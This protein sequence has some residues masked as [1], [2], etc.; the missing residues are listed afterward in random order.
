MDIL[1]RLTTILDRDP[2]ALSLLGNMN[3]AA[4]SCGFNAKQLL[5]A[6]ETTL[7]AAIKQNPEAFGLYADYI[8]KINN[9]EA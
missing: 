4:I 6:Q 5:K 3:E 7:L 2:K 9:K 8:F 1:T